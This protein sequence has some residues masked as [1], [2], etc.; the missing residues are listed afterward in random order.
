MPLCTLKM[1]C[2]FTFWHSRST[3]P[4]MA[5]FQSTKRW[6]SRNRT[7]SHDATMPVLW[8]V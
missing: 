8:I 2:R 1:R 4:E 6:C 3:A 7:R 5:M